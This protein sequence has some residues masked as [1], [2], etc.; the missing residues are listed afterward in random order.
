MAVDTTA[1]DAT[2]TTV[3]VETVAG[4]DNK[5]DTTEAKAPNQTVT[6]KVTG[7]FTAGD[8]VV[9]KVGTE[10]IGNGTV[11]ANGN[12]SI[13]VPTAKLVNA[14]DKKVTATITATD[15]AGN[16]GEVVSA[17]KPYTVDVER[18]AP[19]VTIGTQ[20]DKPYGE[21]VE[22]ITK[23]EITTSGSGESAVEKVSVSVS[24]PNDAKA[25]DT[26]TLTTNTD[27]APITYTVQSGDIGKTITQS[28]TAPADGAELTVSAT[29]TAV[30]DT[31]AVSA[32]GEAKATRDTSANIEVTIGGPDYFEEHPDSEEHGSYVQVIVSPDKKTMTAHDGEVI[33]DME[34]TLYSGE[35]NK[36][37][38][39]RVT[40][41]LPSDAKAGD[42]LTYKVESGGERDAEYT[43]DGLVLRDITSPHT[44]TPPAVVR[45]LT[46]TD[47]QAGKV[48]VYVPAPTKE[49]QII[50]VTASLTDKL[51]NKGEDIQS[52]YRIRT[53][54][55]GGNAELE[56]DP[57]ILELSVNANTKTEVNGKELATAYEGVA[58]SKLTYTVNLNKAAQKD[59]KVAI[60]LSGD[61]ITTDEYAVDGT[62]A[63]WYPNGITTTNGADINQ[64]GSIVVVTIPKGES[65]ASFILTPKEDG[66]TEGTEVVKAEVV[67]AFNFGA[68]EG[69]TGGNGN[70]YTLGDKVVAEGA[71][72]EVD[73]TPPTVSIAVKGN[74][75]EDVLYPATEEDI[76]PN[77]VL[78]YTVSI[79]KARS[80]DTVVKVA[81][82]GKA[83]A[84]DYT[85]RV[86]G[87]EVTGTDYTTTVD[88]E[89]ISGK[90]IEVTIPAGQTSANFTVDP[91]RE[92]SGADYNFE[93]PE[94]VVGTVLAD[95]ASYAIASQGNNQGSYSVG[96]IL[97]SNP[98][99]LPHLNGD[100]SLAYGI[101][102]SWFIQNPTA[103]LAKTVSTEA[104]KVA[105]SGIATADTG[106]AIIMTDRVDKLYIGYHSNGAASTSE[107]N[108][109]I[110]QDSGAARAQTDGS[111]GYIATID[112]G[113][114]DDILQI[115]GRQHGIGGVGNTRIY[116]G[117]GNDLLIIGDRSGGNSSVEDNGRIFAEAGDDTINIGSHLYNHL[118][119]G[120]GGDTITIGGHATGL[121]DLGSGRNMPAEY[122]S[123][124]QDGSGRSLGNDNNTDLATDVNKL[125]IKGA[126]LANGSGHGSKIYGGEGR[127]EV[128]FESGSYVGD[129]DLGNG[130]N[131]VTIK[132]GYSLGI[133][134][135]GGTITTGTGNDQ[136][137]IDGNVVGN[138]KIETGGGND[139]VT[140]GGNFNG[141]FNGG[142]GDDTLNVRGNFSGTYDGGAD[143]DTLEVNGNF[144]GTFNGGAGTDTLDVG[145]NFSGTFNG[146]AGNDTL[147]VRGNFT[148]TFNGGEGDDLIKVEGTTIN[149][150]IDGG[151]GKD[152]ILVTG[153][154]ATLNFSNIMNVETIDLSGEGAQTLSEVW[155]EQVAKSPAASIYV[156][157]TDADTVNLGMQ[158]GDTD[159][160]DKLIWGSRTPWTKGD[161]VEHEG[162]NYV[163]YSYSRGDVS[164]TMYIQENV[165][166][167]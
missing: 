85:V 125:I 44:Y 96:L 158:S 34:T 128:T 134:L 57:A 41:K 84:E 37:G 48:E 6:G 131:I 100:M 38:N 146:E 78:T 105:R 106:D 3:T 136:I 140:V 20:V 22:Y 88:G 53:P 112:M 92:E 39:V 163:T 90:Q 103:N 59:Y 126:G 25:G 2:T 30:D 164:A 148:G 91:I 162:A 55:N 80:V 135:D 138:S 56:G 60:K 117:E 142:A 137:T 36:D 139:S 52:S 23:A 155:A 77:T 42:T 86:N 65:S 157:G 18:T 5:V 76:N 4:D 28:V 118:Y 153:A 72:A 26:L 11:D 61:G 45:E 63:Q 70:F 50:D 24:I 21:D 62:N 107:G 15:E 130:D 165:N 9:V 104:G 69:K 124:Y 123:T 46:D 32:P 145:N 113:K 29:I 160:R 73:N 133:A 122:L 147:N 98:V 109:A 14:A 156:K 127:D 19:T 108:F 66:A 119:A 93:G 35:V 8:A 67:S 144:T 74:I 111:N 159:L 102:S 89:T 49:K 110:S 116:L 17:E 58:D 7:E 95:D 132:N 16:T 97:D 33:Q 141:T 43:D 75:T 87:Q 10:E 31:T 68:A 51:G 101:S 120:S 54:I 152:T 94:T 13:V 150:T 154:G 114:G 64:D 27:A 166:V 79:A 99:A 161:T 129:M 83:T 1:P 81:L 143:S 82:T 121:I 115:R 151:A 12:F 40:F 149:G 47:I 167:I 71:I